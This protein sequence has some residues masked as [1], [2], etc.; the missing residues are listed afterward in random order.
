MRRLAAL[1]LLLILPWT[2]QAEEVVLGLS[3]DEV[4]I[5]ATFDGSSILIFGAVKREAPPPTDLPLDV[6]IAVQGPTE[7]VT[8]RKKARRFGIWINSGAVEIDVAPSF[9]AVATTRPL[10]VA[11]SQT[12]DLRHRVSLDRAVRTIGAAEEAQDAPSYLAALKRL[13]QGEGSYLV[14]EGAV[15]LD[16]ETL[17]RTS[18]RMPANL[19][20]GNYKTR[21]FLTRGGQV[22][23]SYET[24]IYVHKV[25]LERW[26]FSLAH[27]QPLVYGALSLII[28][29][30]AGWAAS[31]AFAALRR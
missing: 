5:T 29:I 23:D 24:V 13:R 1:L 9:Y 31:A 7:T 12:E 27:E 21:I 4:A 10:S 22:V 16:Q 20:V 26:T 28:A 15:A 8:V 17:F 11:L 3:Q 18:I 14:R 2:A 19:T 30:A 25:G 6:V